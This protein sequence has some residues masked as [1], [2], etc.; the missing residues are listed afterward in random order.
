VF[1][2]QHLLIARLR[3]I[4]NTGKIGAYFALK[5]TSSKV[6]VSKNKLVERKN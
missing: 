1:D 6:Y 4:F 5:V 3:N 2:T